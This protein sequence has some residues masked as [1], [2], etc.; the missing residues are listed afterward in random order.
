MK[1]KLEKEDAETLDATLSV[2]R[3]TDSP[4]LNY[5]FHT[6]LLN[7][8]TVGDTKVLLGSPFY[9]SQQ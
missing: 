5:S 7:E 1:I 9:L 6:V 4:H 8:G 3:D 2:Y